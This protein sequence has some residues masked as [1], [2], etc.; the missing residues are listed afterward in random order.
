MNMMSG[1]SSVAFAA[2]LVTAGWLQVARADFSDDFESYNLGDAP[3]APW[4]ITDTNATQYIEVIADDS[5]FT[6]GSKAVN[7]VDTNTEGSNP[8]LV[9]TLPT[10]WAGPLRIEFD[11]KI[12]T[13]SG[14]NITMFLRGVDGGLDGYLRLYSGGGLRNQLDTGTEFIKGLSRD[15]WMHVE[16]LTSSINPSG[17]ETW[18]I[19]ATREDGSGGSLSTQIRKEVDTAYKS[20]LFQDGSG[21]AATSDWV[22]DNFVVTLEE[23]VV[24]DGTF[25]DDFEAQTL[26]EE[27]GDPWIVTDTPV[28]QSLNIASNESFFTAGTNAVTYLDNNTNSTTSNP[29]LRYRLPT[30]EEGPLSISFDYIVTSNSGQAITMYLCGVDDGTDLHLRLRAGGAIRNKTDAEEELIR[31]IPQDTWHRVEILTSGIN[32]NGLETYDITVTRED[33]SVTE[34]TGL[35]FRRDVDTA[36]GS[37]YFQDVSGAIETSE[38]TIDNFSLFALNTVSFYDQWTDKYD[39]TGGDADRYADPDFD[40]VVNLGEWA[41]GGNPT[42]PLSRGIPSTYEITPEGGTN[43]FVYTYVSNSLATDLIY[44]IETASDLQVADW[45]GLSHEVVGVSDS[46]GGFNYITNRVS[47]DS[48]VRFIRSVVEEA[49]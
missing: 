34:V 25:V 10:E 45:N 46:L 48:A 19:T 35:E 49:P 39:L 12:I 8:D 20:I 3:G 27:V 11:Y 6:S 23:E 32:T 4:E 38:W 18:T 37:V 36:Y 33:G 13:N 14:V 41:W 47:T 5:F 9:Y 7:Y 44:D 24:W 17:P 28:G 16:I 26:G 29:D 42:N 31:G 40:Q 43:W 21:S 22:I 2:L 15:Q 30:P 1:N